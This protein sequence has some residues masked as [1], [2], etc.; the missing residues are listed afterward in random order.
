ML[1]SGILDIGSLDKMVKFTAW[2]IFGLIHVRFGLN[3][4]TKYDNLSGK[5]SIFIWFW[6]KFG[7]V[8]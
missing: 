6:F 8:G 3:S 1:G 5:N 2:L 4:K 7:Y